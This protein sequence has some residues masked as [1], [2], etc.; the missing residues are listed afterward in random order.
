MIS[1]LGSYNLFNRIDGKG[2]LNTELNTGC[3]NPRESFFAA[4]SSLKKT[5]YRSNF[6]GF[7]LQDFCKQGNLQA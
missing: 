5:T 3:Y 1:Y 6:Q 4:L 2:N 7:S